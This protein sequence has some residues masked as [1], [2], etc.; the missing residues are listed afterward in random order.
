[1]MGMR[2]TQLFWPSWLLL[3]IVRLTMSFLLLFFFLGG[4][5]IS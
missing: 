3:G 1:M 2:L 5:L 4:L